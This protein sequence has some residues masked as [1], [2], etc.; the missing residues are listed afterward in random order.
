VVRSA[1][2]FRHPS[3]LP[4]VSPGGGDEIAPGNRGDIG[5]PGELPIRPL[6]SDTPERS[7]TLFHLTRGAGIHAP[8]VSNM[9]LVERDSAAAPNEKSGPPRGRPPGDAHWRL[10][11]LSTPTSRFRSLGETRITSEIF[12]VT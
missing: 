3:L 9:T 10:R 5:Q 8:K 6:A 12:T 11:Q 4:A 7:R 1:G 2:A